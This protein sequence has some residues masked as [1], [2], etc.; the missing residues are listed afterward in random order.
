MKKI[1]LP[2]E[3]YK[4]YIAGY[5]VRFNKFESGREY[6]I[7]AYE[8]GKRVATMPIA[9]RSGSFV[10]YRDPGGLVALDTRGVSFPRKGKVTPLF[11]PNPED[12][13]LNTVKL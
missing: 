3:G 9:K 7:V 8:N 2:P 11:E 6:K 12:K 4:F 10:F 13:F 1:L 5:N